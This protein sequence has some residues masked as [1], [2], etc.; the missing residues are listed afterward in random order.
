[1]RITQPQI[2]GSWPYLFLPVLAE[3]VSDL[4]KRLRDTVE[5]Q[6]F[7]DNYGTIPRFKPLSDLEKRILICFKDGLTQTRIAELVHR[8]RPRINQLTKK[9]E[10]I[11]LIRR[12][13][14]QND[15]GKRDYNYFYELTPLA[16]E[17]LKGDKRLEQLTPV[18]IHNFRR[19][20]AIIQKTR[21][22]E[23]D[24]RT[25]YQ[26]SWKMRGAIWHMYWFP[27]KGIMPSVSL[28][29]TP[30]TVIGY[31]D[32]H[33]TIAARDAGEAE[34]IGW[35]AIFQAQ[36]SFVESQASFGTFIIMEEIGQQVGELHGAF[37][38][39][40]DNPDM[41]EVRAKGG[42]VGHSDW[43]TDE[44]EGPELETKKKP[45]WTRMEG[46]IKT[47]EALPDTLKQFNEQLNPMAASVSQIQAMML[48][49]ITAIQKEDNLMKYLSSIMNRMES[50]E[51][52]MEQLIE[53]NAR[54]KGS[55]P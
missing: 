21:E 13:N 3:V 53:E 4:T 10:S 46:L 33:Q 14:L 22:P 48:G 28:V 55:A 20:F 37:P 38:M 40:K 23:T 30:R 12:I 16:L 11:G 2:A 32:S 27:G 18:R 15:N 42:K 26:K 47:A 34:A 24:K 36:K 17:L 6:L 52:R 8:S 5:R 19:K 50:M 41:Q 31:V 54:L 49:S 51:K 35:Q 45:N 43:F 44:S 9:M 39:S 29:I 7:F 1:L 25:G